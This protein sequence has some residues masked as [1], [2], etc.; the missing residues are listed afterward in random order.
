[1]PT[2]NRFQKRLAR[3]EQGGRVIG[4][5]HQLWSLVTGPGYFVLKPPSGSADVPS[6]P[7]FDYTEPPGYEPTGWP[8]YRPNEWGLSLIVFARMKDYLRRVAKGVVVGK[9]FRNGA[10]RGQ[11]F[12]LARAD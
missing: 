1:M 5:N 2:F 3:V 8:R 7:Y 9:A 12:V 6:E 11:Y 4:Y 10:P